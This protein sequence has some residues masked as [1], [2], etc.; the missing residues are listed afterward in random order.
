MNRQD[1]GTLCCFRE[2]GSPSFV[3]QQRLKPKPPNDS[4]IQGGGKESSILMAYFPHLPRAHILGGIKILSHV[5]FA[6]RLRFLERGLRRPGLSALLFRSRP[7]AGTG[8][9]R[10]QR[11]NCKACESHKGPADRAGENSSLRN[12]LRAAELEE[13]L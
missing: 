4:A 8:P 1:H 9:P 7:R 11:S 3:C 5:T 10:P 6:P 13:T 12:Q 2:P